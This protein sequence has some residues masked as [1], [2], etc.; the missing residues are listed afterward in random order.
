MVDAIVTM[1]DVILLFGLSFC[2]AAAA[3]TME[4]SSQITAV[5]MTAACGSSFFSSSA[6]TAAETTASANFIPK[7]VAQP[8]TPF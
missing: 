1:E 6:A 2:Y 8:A 5:A 3:T 4:V 7:G